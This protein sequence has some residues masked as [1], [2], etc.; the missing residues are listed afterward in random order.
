MKIGSDYSCG[1]RRN[2]HRLHA[3]DPWRQRVMTALRDGLLLAPE[4]ASLLL[5]EVLERRIGESIFVRHHRRNQAILAYYAAGCF[6]SMRQAAR[7]LESDLVRYAAAGF[8]HDKKAGKRPIGPKGSLFDILE[9]NGGN[10][11][12]YE[13]IYKLLKSRENN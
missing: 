10:T 11:L 12:G 2:R 4:D 9:L 6:S 8:R 5:V 1:G 7:T 13:M 3:N